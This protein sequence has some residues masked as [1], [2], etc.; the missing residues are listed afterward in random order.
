MTLTLRAGLTLDEY[1][2]LSLEQECELVAGELKPKP[3]GTFEHSDIQLQ[4][5]LLLRQEFGRPRTKVEFSIRKGEDVLIPDICVLRPG[6][7]KLYMQVLNEAPLLCVEIVSPSQRVGELF[8]KCEMYH[9]WGVEYCWVVDPVA[10]R[11]WTY[12]GGTAAAMEVADELTGPTTIL[13]S[14]IFSE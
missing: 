9:E 5:S 11:A 14:E 10:R 8:V 12:H 13:L 1:L 2:G 4:L 7:P 6:E 3:R